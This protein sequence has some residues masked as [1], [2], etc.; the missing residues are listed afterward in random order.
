MRRKDNNG[1]IKA[2]NKSHSGA[3]VPM[4]HYIG[5]STNSVHNSRSIKLERKEV[6]D[7]LTYLSKGTPVDTLAEMYSVAKS[8]INKICNGNGSFKYLLGTTELLNMQ[9]A[10]KV[11]INTV[12]KH[13]AVKITR[14]TSPINI[15]DVLIGLA[16]YT[17]QK[18]IAKNNNTNQGLISKVLNAKSPYLYLRDSDKWNN[19]V[20]LRLVR[21]RLHSSVI[22][23]YDSML[24]EHSLDSSEILEECS[25]LE[26]MSNEI[27]F[28]T[29]ITDQ[30]VI[31]DCVDVIITENVESKDI[32]LEAD[33][34]VVGDENMIEKIL[35]QFID[36]K[37]F[38][39][40]YIM[41]TDNNPVEF[42]VNK[43]V[44]SSMVYS[45][46]ALQEI[47]DLNQ[48]EIMLVLNEAMSN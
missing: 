21:F 5:E 16:R 4:K 15:D 36:I 10:R 6:S 9:K 30:T 7:I 26:E 23:L 2:I 29:P 37:V 44:A 11:A 35:K 13:T 1:G 41:F 34:M 3:L 27:K 48:D 32:I 25:V 19:L 18:D 40:R 12:V 28:A 24:D 38:E 45:M 20:K 39:K 8:A 46:K 42:D 17:K 43:D 22:E 14:N 33:E 31:D 47:T